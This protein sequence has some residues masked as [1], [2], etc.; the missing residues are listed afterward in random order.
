MFRRISFAIRYALRNMWRDRQRT[1]FALFSIGAGVAT[2]VALRMLGLMLTDALTANVQAFLRGDIIVQTS[3]RGPTISFLGQSPPPP[4]NARNARLIDE[5]AA[6][7][8]VEVNYSLTSELMQTAIVQGDRAGRPAFVLANFIDPKRYPFYDV[9]RA[10]SPSGVLLSN[11]LQGPNQVV[12]GRR[13]AD[14]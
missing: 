5:W 11:L 14:Q 10:D 8:K 1:A 6:Q 2:V 4:I 3:F 9:I 13:V 7:N 12:V